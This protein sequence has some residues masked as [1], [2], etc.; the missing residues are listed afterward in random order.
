M[1]RCGPRVLDR[2]LADPPGSVAVRKYGAVEF[3]ELLWD[4]L[5]CNFVSFDF[6]REFTQKGYRSHVLHG[7]RW[8]TDDCFGQ[9]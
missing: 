2:G 4:H 5:R 8:L 3:V 7:D 6:G 1:V 9:R